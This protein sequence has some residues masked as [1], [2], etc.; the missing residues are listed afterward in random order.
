MTKFILSA[1]AA[2]TV[3]AIVFIYAAVATMC[4]ETYWPDWD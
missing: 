1:A 2:V 3:A 4:D